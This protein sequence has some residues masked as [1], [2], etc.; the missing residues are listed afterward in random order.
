M[1][2][3]HTFNNEEQ[4]TFLT[5]FLLLKDFYNSSKTLLSTVWLMEW[6]RHPF[7]MINTYN[8]FLQTY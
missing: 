1:A 6:Y 8:T 3:T 5:Y 4:H 7:L 2:K